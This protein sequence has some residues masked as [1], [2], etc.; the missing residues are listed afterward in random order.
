MKKSIIFIVG[1]I[2]LVSFVFAQEIEEIRIVTYYP[3]PYGSYTELRSQRMAI[4]DNYSNSASYEWGSTIS[5]SADLVVEGNVGIGTAEPIGTLV[6]GNNVS[7][8][9]IGGNSWISVGLSGARN[10][11]G[12]VLGSDSVNNRYLQL[13]WNDNVNR[14]QINT[15]SATQPLVLQNL[16]NGNVG[17][18]IDNPSSKLH[19]GDGSLAISESTTGHGLFANW[20][21]AIDTG[22]LGIW[23]GGWGQFYFNTVAPASTRS[24]GIGVN[25]KPS[26][27]IHIRSTGWQ[28]YLD[29]AVATGG[30]GFGLGVQGTD[31]WSVWK[32][33]SGSNHDL[34]FRWAPTDTEIVRIDGANQRFGILR[35]PTANALEVNGNAS[36]SV[37][38]SW[39]A[40]SDIRI[41]TAIETV[42]G[43]KD[44]IEKLRPVKFRYKQDYLK[45]HPEIKDRYYYNFIAQEFKDVFPHSVSDNGEGLLQL[46]TYNVNIFLVAAVQEIIEENNTLKKR[47]ETLEAQ[48]NKE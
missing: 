47:I 31:Y 8:L 23:D 7:G 3:A 11:S 1:L 19:I 15:S 4:G 16:S 44:I 6:V 17:I 24:A 22:T 46:D 21:G 14:A 9:G 20:D 34:I 13:D 42:T 40:N 36:K 27:P 37:A 32:H 43:G 48:F 35:D 39:L 5:S 30:S 28:M 26:Y 12:I 2:V 33:G 18:G 41:K 10:V 29:A 38:G 25:T 45:K